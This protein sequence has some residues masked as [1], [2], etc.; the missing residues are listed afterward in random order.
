MTKLILPRRRALLLA[1]S[2]L[3]APMVASGVARAG[4]DWPNKPVKYI[5]LF[6][7]GGPTDVLSRIACQKLSE[8]TGLQF[9]AD[10]R[11]GSGGNV[12]AEAIKNSAPDGYRIGLRSV[13]SHAI[14][15]TL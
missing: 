2:T 5:N 6:P 9:I 10:D 14:A 12:C 13:S 11:G 8:L 3:A 4:D 1:G 7:A 15:T